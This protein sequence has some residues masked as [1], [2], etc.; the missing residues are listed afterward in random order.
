[1]PLEILYIL[2][3]LFRSCSRTECA[4][5]TTLFGFGINLSGIKTVFTAF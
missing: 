5:I 3:M 4:Q 2:F 1:M